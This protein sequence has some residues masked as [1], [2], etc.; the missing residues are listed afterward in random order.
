MTDE[1]RVDPFKHLDSRPDD[2]NHNISIKFVAKNVVVTVATAPKTSAPLAEDK[3]NSA[4]CNT[5]TTKSQC[6]RWIFNVQLTL[7]MTIIHT[8]WVISSVDLHMELGFP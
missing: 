3:F 4:S 7:Q 8:N 2:F 1:K 6:P 5:S